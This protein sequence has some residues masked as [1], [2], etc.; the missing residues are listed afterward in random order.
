LRAFAR[1]LQVTF[2]QDDIVCRSGGEEFLVIL[3]TADTSIVS[4]R[5][6][7]LRRSIE[8]MPI[9]YSGKNLPAVTVSGGVAIYPQHATTAAEL[10]RAAD[11]ALYQA[12]TR[13]RNRI[14][15]TG[16]PLGAGAS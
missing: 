15:V 12:K 8:Q 6:E 13:G 4:Q 14:V 5:A 11:V 3:P 9:S 1:L 2:R 7:D 10:L 16:S